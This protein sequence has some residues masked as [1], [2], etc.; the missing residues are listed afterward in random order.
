MGGVFGLKTYLMFTKNRKWGVFRK[1]FI[2]P[3]IPIRV[4]LNNSLRNYTIV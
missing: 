4:K 3:Y 2:Y 1:K